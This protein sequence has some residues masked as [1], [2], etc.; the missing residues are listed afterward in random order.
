MSDH[1]VTADTLRNLK[2]VCQNKQNLVIK[3][4]ISLLK[5]KVSSKPALNLCVLRKFH[6][7]FSTIIV[8]LLIEAKIL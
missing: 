6:S 4:Y 1:L 3:K 2:P 8:V 7:Y 5:L